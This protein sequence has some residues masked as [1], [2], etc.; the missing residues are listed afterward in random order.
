MAVVG[1]LTQ[2]P[3]ALLHSGPELTVHYQFVSLP[4]L[5]STQQR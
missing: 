2:A 3:D 4:A 5:L 1:E